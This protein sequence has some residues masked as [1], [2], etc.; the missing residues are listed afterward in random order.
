MKPSDSDRPFE[1]EGEEP[2]ELA[3]NEFDWERYFR[4]QDER[5]YR[6]LAFY[7][8]LRAHP[9]RIDEVARLMG[10]EAAAACDDASAASEE[11]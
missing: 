5:L 3:W 10:W 2:G 7:E 1:G 9:E 4:E 8:K 11:A 6:Y